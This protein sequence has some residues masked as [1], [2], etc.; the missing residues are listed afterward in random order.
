MEAQR[1]VINDG[2]LTS[3]ES[4]N[5]SLPGWIYRD[6]EF[7]EAEKEAVFASSWQVVCHLND[8]PK[9]GDFH[10]LEFLSE[11]LVA[12]RQQ[13]GGVKAFYNVCRHRAARLMDGVGSCPGRI[14][15]PYHAWTYDLDGRLTAV[16]QKREF[17]EFSVERYGLKS[18][19]TEVFKGFVFVRLKSGLP[20]VAEMLAPY[21]EE[22]AAYRFEDLIPMGRVTLRTR[23]VN[24]KNVTDNYSDSMHI[25]VAHPG[26][27]RLFGMSYG[28]EAQTWVDKMWGYLRDA[29]SSQL[30][31][32]LYQKLLPEI[33]YLPQERQKLW[34]YFK[35]WPNIAFDIYPDQIDF[36]QMIPVSPTET[37]IREIAYAIPDSRRE[38]RSVRYLNW[39]INRRVSVEDKSLIERVQSG[40][41][42]R[43]YTPGPLGRNEVALRSFARRMRDLIP[44]SRLERPPSAGWHHKNRSA[45]LG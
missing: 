24:W 16:P 19:E 31:E 25:P 45:H 43:S 28:L 3:A 23:H 34:T 5:F 12:V 4:D 8:I 40:M 38:M 37:L 6:Q 18:L 39:R 14:V 41:T 22:L 32:R 29:P 42:S 13:N 1:S 35:L 7:L 21:A 15:C 36:M 11:P 20:S 9:A 33:P 27:T 26:L 30:S 44:E 2:T 17:H 10:T